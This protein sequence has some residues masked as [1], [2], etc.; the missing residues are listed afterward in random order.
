MEISPLV[1]SFLLFYSFLWGALIGLLNDVNKIIRTFL[2][3]EYSY[4]IIKFYSFFKINVNTRKKEPSVTK[5]IIFN[6]LIFFQDL[7]FIIIA[8]VG[9]IILN[10]YYNDGYFR[11]F[12]FLSMTVGFFFYWLLISKVIMKLFVPIISFSRFL[13]I[14]AVTPF[15]VLF[16]IIKKFIV[17]ILST[18]KKC[19]EKKQEIR[20]NKNRRERLIKY[21]KKGFDVSDSG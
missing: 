12:S 17:K 1:L 2:C 18:L 16:R 15:L 7:S 5:K 8:A 19:I 21:S 20:Y 6:G 9:I 13:I 14:L 4:S 11:F 10:Y 3:G